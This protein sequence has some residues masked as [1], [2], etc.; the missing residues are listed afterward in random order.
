MVESYSQ[1]ETTTSVILILEKKKVMVPTPGRMAI[2]IKD[3]GKKTCIM[4][5]VNFIEK[6]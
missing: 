1:M 4:V 2:T 6:L 3:H 5:K